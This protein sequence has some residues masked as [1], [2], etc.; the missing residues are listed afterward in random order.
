MAKGER[1]HSRFNS[2]VMDVAENHVVN[3]RTIAIDSIARTHQREASE[4][5]RKSDAR[6]GGVLCMWLRHLRS[7]CWTLGS[8]LLDQEA[9]RDVRVLGSTEL[10][11]LWILSNRN[12]SSSSAQDNIYVS[13]SETGEVFV[14]KFG[15]KILARQRQ[16]K[17]WR[18]L[19][20][21]CDGNCRLRRS[22]F[23]SP[24][25]CATGFSLVTPTVFIRR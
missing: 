13:D 4:L 17:R 2:G 6:L 10:F 22:A 7:S 9:N 18:R 20:Q 24:T 12:I 21:T 5:R 15:W 11:P 3:D 8:S 1:D 25:R 19:L 16:H 23:M 14:F